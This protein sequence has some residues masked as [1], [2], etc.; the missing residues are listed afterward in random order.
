MI[1]VCIIGKYSEF[2]AMDNF[3]LTNIAISYFN[4]EYITFFYLLKKVTH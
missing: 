1:N 4:V 3:V 2:C